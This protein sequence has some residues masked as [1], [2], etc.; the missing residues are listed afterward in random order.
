LTVL[1]STL[2]SDDDFRQMLKTV[3]NNKLKPV[4]DSVHPLE[5][6]KDAMTRMERA[7]Q[8]GKIVLNVSK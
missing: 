5:K 8:F 6:V 4:I 3:N 7:E 2:G 1:G